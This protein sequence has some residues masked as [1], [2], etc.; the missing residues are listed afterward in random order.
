MF[1][2]SSL[3]I[4]KTLAP[5]KFTLPT[6]TRDRDVWE[7]LHFNKTKFE[8]VLLS[9]HAKRFNV[10]HMQDFV[11]T[12]LSSVCSFIFLQCLEAPSPLYLKMLPNETFVHYKKYMEFQNLEESII[13]VKYILYNF[14]HNSLSTKSLFQHS[15][16][17]LIFFSPSVY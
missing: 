9:A 10:S 4:F 8:S 11:D 16:M 17:N 2:P 15:A 3:F 5:I 12:S 7:G 13:S 14:F 1:S 6:G